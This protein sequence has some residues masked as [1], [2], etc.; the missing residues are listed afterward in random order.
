VA[1]STG[2]DPASSSARLVRV[3][4]GGNSRR[5]AMYDIFRSPSATAFGADGYLVPSCSGDPEMFYRCRV[6]VLRQAY[7]WIAILSAI[8]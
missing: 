5:S 1:L 3:R 2:A 4:H 6:P 8:G 7:A